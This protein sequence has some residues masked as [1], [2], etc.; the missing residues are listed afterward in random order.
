MRTI[1]LQIAATETHCCS[2]GTRCDF[3]DGTWPRCDA[4][5]KSKR[6]PEYDGTVGWFRRSPECIAAEKEAAK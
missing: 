3:L 4:F 1:K 2:D 5:P 6:E